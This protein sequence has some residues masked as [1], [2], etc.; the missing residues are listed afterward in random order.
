MTSISSTWPISLGPPVETWNVETPCNETPPE[1]SCWT[2]HARAVWNALQNHPVV[3]G[4]PIST[5]IIPP[6]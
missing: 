4:Q 2:Q 5:I 1:E 6:P 3:P